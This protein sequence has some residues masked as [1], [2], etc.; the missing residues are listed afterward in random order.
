MWRSIFG[1]FSVRVLSALLN[2][3]LVILFSQ[4]TGTVG[5]GEQSLVLT[6]VAIITIFDSLVGGAALVYLSSRYSWTQ[7]IKASYTWVLVVSTFA[8]L[9]LEAF[10]VFET[11]YLL[12]IILLS[13]ISSVSSVHASLLMGQQR[14]KAFNL[15]QILVPLLTFSTCVGQWLLYHPLDYIDALY[16]SYMVALLTS[17]IAI[18]RFFPQ[19]EQEVVSR[20]M[21]WQRLFKLGFYNQ[22]AHVLQLLSFRASYYILEQFHGTSAVGVFSNASSITESIWLIASSISLWQYATISN[23]QDQQYTIQITEKLSRFGMLAAF[24]GVGFFLF[25][26]PDFYQFVFG[27]DFGGLQKLMWALAPGVWVFT[28]ALVVGHYFS[29]HG[30]YWVNALAS[31][32]GL[33]FSLLASFI[34]IPMYGAIGAALAASMS[35]TATSLVVLRYFLKDGAQFSVFPSKEELLQLFTQMRVLWRKS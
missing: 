25:L 30:R 2:L 12:H 27:A 17:C 8:F 6:S 19:Q 29:G 15:I 1:N 16:V 26:P 4:L 33:V 23:T 31:G 20:K 35:Y 13:A 21:I 14:L 24:F 34:F 32:V 22:L 7:L 5:K 3:G 18:W 10:H 9:I 28:Y 11:K